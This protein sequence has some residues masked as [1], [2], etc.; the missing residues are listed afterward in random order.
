MG[1]L[2]ESSI[3]FSAAENAEGLTLPT[4]NG[5]WET[6][7]GAEVVVYIVNAGTSSA[8]ADYVLRTQDLDGDGN[9]N[10]PGEA[11]IWCD[12]GVLVSELLN[13]P[14]NVSSAFEIVFIGDVAYISDSAGGNFV[15]LRA[16]DTNRNGVIDSGELRIVLKLSDAAPLGI[17]DFFSALTKMGPD[18]IIST[19]AGPPGVWF[20]NDKEDS[21]MIDT[22]EDVNQTWNGLNTP[23]GKTVSFNF[24]IAAALSARTFIRPPMMAMVVCSVWWILWA[25][26]TIMHP[27]T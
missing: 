21:G 16:D 9:A 23:P 15:I 17:T 24:G 27:A 18:F 5:I 8:P 3:W 25:M 11:T 6:N 19:F 7:N 13:K 14:P 4:P 1:G 26:A 2:G 22:P 12:L 20:L 10:G